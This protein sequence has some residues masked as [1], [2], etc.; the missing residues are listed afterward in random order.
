M[1]AFE[2]RPVLSHRGSVASTSA[3]LIQDEQN[4]IKDEQLRLVRPVRASPGPGS[5]T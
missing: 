5:H 1:V 3:Q 2:G 4:S